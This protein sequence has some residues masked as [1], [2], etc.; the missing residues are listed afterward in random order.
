MRADGSGPR[1]TRSV[2]PARNPGLRGA[3]SGV[4]AAKGQEGQPLED[5]KCTVVFSS[6]TGGAT[7]QLVTTTDQ[8]GAGNV[9]LKKA[10]VALFSYAP[11]VSM[12]ATVSARSKGGVSSTIGRIS[13][14][15][16]AMFFALMKSRNSLNLLRNV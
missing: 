7:S 5:A 15:T 12:E 14:G 4:G 16:V 8:S 10:S 1:N 13:D 9:T 2:P 11:G 6:K 3:K